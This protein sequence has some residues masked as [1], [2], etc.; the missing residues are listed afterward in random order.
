MRS[1]PIQTS[2]SNGELASFVP[3]QFKDNYNSCLILV[4]RKAEIYQSF[5]EL[6]HSQVIHL[7]SN[8]RPDVSVD[9]FHS[10]NGMFSWR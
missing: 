9:D 8:L 7:I 2:Q 4:T 10:G 1:T 5:N 3:G 6:L